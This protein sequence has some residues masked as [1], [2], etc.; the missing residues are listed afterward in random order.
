[1]KAFKIDHAVLAP[2][3]P[4]ELAETERRLRLRA[5]SQTDGSARRLP[6]YRATEQEACPMHGAGRYPGE[7]KSRWRRE[8][9][10]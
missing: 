1:M 5:T 8:C 4:P 9:R 7:A 3:C 6:V 2:G 10:Y